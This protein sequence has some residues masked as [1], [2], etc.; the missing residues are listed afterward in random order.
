MD[1][2]VC[3]FS[4]FID[5]CCVCCP[6][7]QEGIALLPMESTGCCCCVNP[8]RADWRYN[9]CGACGPADGEPL[10]RYKTNIVTGL[11]EGEG[12][13][14]AHHINSARAEWAYRTGYTD[15]AK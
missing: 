12:A 8:T 3:F 4:P 6:Q 15:D 7:Q 2:S 1:P 5:C 11:A 13:R 9:L 14:L 10:P